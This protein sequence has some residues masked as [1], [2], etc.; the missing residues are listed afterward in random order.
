MTTFYHQQF[1]T[2]AKQDVIVGNYWRYNNGYNLV[3]GLVRKRDTATGNPTGVINYN[4]GIDEDKCI[5]YV[6]RPGEAYGEMAE[7][8]CSNDCPIICRL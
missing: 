3:D 4:V 7:R 5:E 8:P 1:W 2:D 6:R